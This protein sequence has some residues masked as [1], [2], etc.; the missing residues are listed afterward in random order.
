MLATCIIVWTIALSRFVAWR[1]SR[2]L[3]GGFEQSLVQVLGGRRFTRDVHQMLKPFEI[4]ELLPGHFRPAN[5][6]V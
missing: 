6:E 2:R 3:S 1:V 5:L 4:M